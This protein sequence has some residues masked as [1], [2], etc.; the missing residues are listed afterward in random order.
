MDKVVVEEL[1]WPKQNLNLN[2]NK[3]FC[4]ELECRLHLRP[5][6]LTSAPKLI[7][8]EGTTSQ[9]RFQIPEK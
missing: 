3:H 5:P 9:S 4:H 1:K 6:H 2:H 7:V 8:S